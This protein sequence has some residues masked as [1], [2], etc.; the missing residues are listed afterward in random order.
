M[1]LDLKE[2]AVRAAGDLREWLQADVGDRPVG[3][4]QHFCAL[5][6]LG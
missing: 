2:R 1:V 3:R 5:R 6:Q 4:R